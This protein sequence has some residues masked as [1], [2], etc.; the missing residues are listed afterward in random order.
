MSYDGDTYFPCRSFSVSCGPFL[1]TAFDSVVGYTRVSDADLLL[2]RQY[3]GGSIRLSASLFAAKLRGD[4][5][6]GDGIRD[7]Y[8]GIFEYAT[9][10]HVEASK[11]ALIEKSGDEE[12]AGAW[13][14]K[15][16]VGPQKTLSTNDLGDP[17]NWDET[18]ME[19]R[20]SNPRIHSFRL[21][22]VGRYRLRGY[23]LL[24]LPPDSVEPVRL[25]EL[26]SRVT[27]R[28]WRGG[29]DRRG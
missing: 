5:M 25:A 11:L 3:Q 17:L 23:L 19:L 10:E 24:A 13:A 21:E 14:L 1:P 20:S 29:S 15:R 2:K 26:I 16:I 8:T 12:G 18:D 9:Y 4:S 27:K 7:G 22:R 28:K 6:I